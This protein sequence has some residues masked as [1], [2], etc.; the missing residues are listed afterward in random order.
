MYLRG[1]LFENLSISELVKTNLN[2]RLNYRFWFWRDN[3][4]NE[5]D[6]L[7]E[8]GSK[9][10]GIEIKSGETFRNE[11]LKPLIFWKALSQSQSNHLYLIYGGNKNLIFND[12]FIEGWKNSFRILLP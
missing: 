12:I 11:F 6:L 8:T 5:I 9:M 1:H 4:K 2:Y 3:H 10:L 7:I